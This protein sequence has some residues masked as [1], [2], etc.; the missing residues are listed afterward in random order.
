M[1]LNDLDTVI[2]GRYSVRSWQEKDVPEELLLQAIE[3]AT[4]APNGGNQQNWRFY[5]VMN[6]DTIGA[7]ADAVQAKAD[8]MASWPDADKFLGVNRVRSRA[9]FFRGAPAVIA[10]ASS[11]YQSPVDKLLEANEGKEAEAGVIRRWR[12][13]ADSRIQ[14]VSAAIAYLLLVLH[15]MGIGSLWMTGPMQAKE[16]IENILKVPAEFDII[17]LIP[18][19]YAADGP[20]DRTRKAIQEVCQ[21]VR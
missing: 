8:K 4:W 13:T 6:K 17:A 7:I 1:E 19:G 15:Q 10:V 16:D 20:G 5:L 21:V 14:S 12:N 3:L 18:V 2:K 11:Q 9:G